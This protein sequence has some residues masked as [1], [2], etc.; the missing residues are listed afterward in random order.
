MHS[1]NRLLPLSSISSTSGDGQALRRGG[2]E[3]V[4]SG[5][6]PPA[7][8]QPFFFRVYFSFLVFLR[9]SCPGRG[10]GGAAEGWKGSGVRE[11]ILLVQAHGR[12]LVHAHVGVA[13]QASGLALDALWIQGVQLLWGHFQVGLHLRTRRHLGDVETILPSWK[14][15]PRARSLERKFSSHKIK[16]LL[17]STV[18]NHALIK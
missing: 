16:L 7:G 14:K 5:Q 15:K 2:V 3:R 8:R 12:A 13:Q 1:A 6:H 17:S 11:R 9:I 4:N 10:G 18:N